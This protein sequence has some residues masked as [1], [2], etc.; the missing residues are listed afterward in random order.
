MFLKRTLTIWGATVFGVLAVMA[1]CEALDTGQGDSFA[2]ESDK[3]RECQ[4][5]LVECTSTS[6]DEQQFVGCRDQWQECQIKRGIGQ[7]FCRNPADADACDLCRAR[8]KECQAG[9]TP[10]ACG[11]EFGVCK[12]FLMTR[13]D[14]AKQ[15]TDAPTPDPA[16]TCGI[17]QKDFVSC[18]SDGTGSTDLPQ[19]DSKFQQCKDANQLESDQCGLPGGAEGCTMCKAEHDGCAAAAG[20]ECEAGF[21]ACR[22][23]IAPNVTCDLDDAGGA[24]A[25]G[26]GQGGGAEGGGGQGG[27]GGGESCEFDPCIEGEVP[28]MS[29]NSCTE[30]VCTEDDYC[31]ATYWDFACTE[32]ALGI[33]DCGCGGV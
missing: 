1:G 28:E 8:L 18:I 22:T 21:G 13:S 33:N 16:V 25:G 30:Q 19:C 4:S 27:A 12:A 15:C 11:D 31:C 26:G 14:V 32:I 6:K 5:I 17:C 24:G 2:T 23:A 3:C 9:S 20:P 29:C 7:G 10:D